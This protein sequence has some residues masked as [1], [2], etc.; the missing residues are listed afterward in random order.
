[1]PAALK[2]LL[3]ATHRPFQHGLTVNSTLSYLALDPPATAQA[4]TLQVIGTGG[5]PTYVH[6]T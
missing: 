4:G 6:G 1:M 3:P 2:G 5:A